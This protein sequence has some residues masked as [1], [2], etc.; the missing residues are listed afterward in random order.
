MVSGVRDGCC[1]AHLLCG[2]SVKRYVL[3]LFL[4]YPDYDEAYYT[5]AR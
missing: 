1:A 2:T 4:L 3:G 5:N